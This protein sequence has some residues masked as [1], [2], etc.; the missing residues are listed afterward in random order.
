M[1]RF[2]TRLFLIIVALLIIPAISTTRPNVKNIAQTQPGQ[3]SFFQDNFNGSAIDS[4]KWN[5]TF[6]TSGL[7][8]CSSTIANHE[9]N[10]GLWLDPSLAPCHGIIQNPPFATISV[11]GGSATFSSFSSMAAPY[12]WSGPPSKPSPFPSTGNFLLEVKMQ[13]NQ[14]NGSGDGFFVTSWNNANPAGDNPPGGQQRVLLIWGDNQGL[15]VQLLGNESTTLA[16]Q[17]G[18]HDYLLEYAN[19]KYILYV[20]GFPI[21]APITSNARANTIW[22]GNPVFRFWGIDNWSSFSLS[23]VRVNIPSI[24]LSPTQGPVGTKV[25]VTGSNIP[26]KLLYLTFDDMFLGQT[27]TSNET[28]AFTLDVPN[29]QSGLHQIKAVDPLT[30]LIAST[31]FIVTFVPSNLALTLSTGTIYFPGDTATINML[32]SSGGTD[33]SANIT[34][35]VTLITPNNSTVALVTKFMGSGL[36][37]ALYSIPKTVALGTY[38]LVAIARITG[39]GEASTLGAFE[40]KPSWLSQQGPAI[41]TAGVGSLAA[42]A[43]GLVLWRK[44]TLG[45]STKRP[46]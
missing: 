16:N 35:E 6:G 25:L 44:G 26:S 34:V 5:S 22:I 7:R 8:W 37:R 24:Q 3:S 11:G 29:A 46:L 4:T 15:T 28:F 12:I 18:M 23:Q 42:I 1:K 14:F 9:D 32:V 10:P 13:Y 27:T 19:G 30:D 36:F 41:A 33:A 45:K 2:A 20:D 38:S 21:L 43:M 17:Y 39:A 40:V 31:S